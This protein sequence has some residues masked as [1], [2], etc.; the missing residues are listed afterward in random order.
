M[1]LAIW[2]LA[3]ALTFDFPSLSATAFNGSAP[4]RPAAD[5]APVF[6][7]HP[8]FER[9]DQSFAIASNQCGVLVLAARR[10]PVPSDRT[11][12]CDWKSLTYRVTIPDGF[13]FVD[14]TCAE[15]SSVKRKAVSDGATEVSF[16][17]RSRVFLPP[18]AVKG[19][20]RFGL[21]LRAVK[22]AS[23]L[24]SICA[25]VPG[26]TNAPLLAVKLLTIPSI[27]ASTPRRFGVGAYPD[28]ASHYFPTAAGDQAFADQLRSAGV[29][30]LIPPRP[31]VK[32]E[33]GLSNRLARWRAAGIRRITPDAS[34]VLAN[35]YSLK[36]K[37]LPRVNDLFIGADPP[38]KPL[39]R[40]VLCPAAIHEEREIFVRGALPELKDLT[41]GCDGFWCNWEPFVFRTKGCFCS[42]CRARFAAFT[43][44]EEEVVAADWPAGLLPGGRWFADGCRFRR[45]EHAKVVQTIV[46]CVKDWL[47]PDA[48]GFIPGVCWGDLASGWQSRWYCSE[49]S[50]GD[51]M[52]ELDW[53][54]PFG[55]YVHWDSAKPFDGKDGAMLATFFAAREVRCQVDRDNPPAGSK[56][57][58]AFPY[59]LIGDTWLTQPEWIRMAQEVFFWLGWDASIPWRFPEGA[60][61]R[62]WQA[63]AEASD[64]IAKYEDLRVG[65]LV[66][67]EVL[68]R[69]A[70]DV[71]TRALG[72]WYLTR[73][74][75]SLFQ[76]VV[77]KS[78]NG[79]R[80]VVVFNFSDTRSLSFT[81]DPS[82]RYP[83]GRR[84]SI[85]PCTLQIFEEH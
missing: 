82:F 84:L 47:P 35:G 33:G 64:H 16:R 12:A 44:L 30:W 74:P 28:A 80:F 67:D 42:A 20:G 53:V 11:D 10:D 76:Q 62:Y 60:D 52:A 36:A 56:K 54:N 79:R 39:G 48:C 66:T 4:A 21:A 5:P 25:D 43:G 29:N 23:G 7:S 78:S 75:Q 2:G 15:P 81:L 55:P 18:T 40:T 83:S 70:V 31:V 32:Q 58:M 72:M 13:E 26:A 50:I 59:G 24:L 57:L 85:L 27:Q 63:F 65:A 71:P 37:V 49:A 1:L 9:L 3:A 38:D 41:A 51:S 69:P 61:A 73:K 19:G 46:R 22:G 34:G 14:A 8:V 17:L 45:A 77:F 68:A 6:F